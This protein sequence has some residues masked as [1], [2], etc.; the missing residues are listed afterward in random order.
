[1]LEGGIEVVPRYLAEPGG[2]PQKPYARRTI[3]PTLPPPTGY[4]DVDIPLI[5]AVGDS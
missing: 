5:I 3:M 1:M 2:S 4:D